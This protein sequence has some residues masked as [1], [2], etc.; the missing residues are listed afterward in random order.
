MPVM[1]PS[2]RPVIVVL[3]SFLAASDASSNQVHVIDGDTFVFESN[4]IR[5]ANIDAPETTQAKCDAERMLGMAAKRRLIE[6]LDE[7]GLVVTPGD[8]ASGRERDRYGRL[9]AIVS[10]GGRDV[11]AVLV[12]EGLARKWKGHRRPWC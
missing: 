1:R 4:T 9:L 8:P 2:M 11:G 6:L 10:V 7:G 5:I 12:A 3:A